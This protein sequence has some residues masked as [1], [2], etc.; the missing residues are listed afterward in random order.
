M[1]RKFSEIN[2]ER[3]NVICKW[4]GKNKLEKQKNGN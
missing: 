2:V 4:K 1:K 3:E